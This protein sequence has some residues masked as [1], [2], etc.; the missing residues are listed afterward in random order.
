M[1]DPD[2][3]LVTFLSQQEGTPGSGT[4]LDESVTASTLSANNGATHSVTQKKFGATSID[5]TTTKNFSAGS[6]GT[7][8]DF[9]KNEFCI[10]GSPLRGTLTT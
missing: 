5:C 10:E 7:S 2:F 3:D 4:I 9:G 6:Y 8:L 1:S